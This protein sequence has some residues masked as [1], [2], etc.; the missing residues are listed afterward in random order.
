MS[1][2]CIILC[3]LFPGDSSVIAP[4]DTLQ[5]RT[6]GMLDMLHKHTAYAVQQLVLQHN[7]DLQELFYPLAV[8]AN[9]S[10]PCH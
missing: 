2:H 4:L 6:A 1:K 10:A 7:I 8:S 9:S 3:R 5:V